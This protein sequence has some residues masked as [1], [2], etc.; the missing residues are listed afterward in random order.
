MIDTE[1]ILH[2]NV[3]YLHMRPIFYFSVESFNEAGEKVAFNQVT[4]FV[5]KA[6]GFGGRRTS[7]K[8]IEPA[9]PPKRAPDASVK[10]A[11]SVDQVS[12]AR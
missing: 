2:R 4:T 12:E 9:N 8:A 6:G 3:A 11:I 1:T 7:D 10:Q 5:Q